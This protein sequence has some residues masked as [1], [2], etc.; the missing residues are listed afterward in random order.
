M[1]ILTILYFNQGTL[2]SPYGG[3]NTFARTLPDIR[4]LADVSVAS[5]VIYFPTRKLTDETCLFRPIGEL[6]R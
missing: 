2:I 4:Q 3:A 1:T 6:A 5:F